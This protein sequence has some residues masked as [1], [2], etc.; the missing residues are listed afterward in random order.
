MDKTGKIAVAIA[1]TVM[2]GWMVYQAK[3]N[4]P[5]PI[6]A[7]APSASPAT[8]GATPQAGSPAPSS[9]QAENPA[10]APEPPE[11]QVPEQTQLISTSLVE[12]TFTNHGGGIA[13]AQLIKHMMDQDS[14]DKGVVLNDY[15][16][17]PIGAASDQ[18]GEGATASYKT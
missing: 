17:V 16:P 1:L 12:F 7:A 6:P 18:P 10:P 2:I 11:P 3:V 8:A 5:P 4:P 14:K 15:G 9:A 13:R